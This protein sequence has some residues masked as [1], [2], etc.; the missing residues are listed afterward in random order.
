M[1]TLLLIEFWKFYKIYSPFRNLSKIRV[2]KE[3]GVSSN[4]LEG[5][6]LFTI[7]KK[8]VRD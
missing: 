6:G 7:F 3:L 1:T 8:K 4:E 5:I 2:I